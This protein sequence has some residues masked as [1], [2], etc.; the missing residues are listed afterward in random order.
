MRPKAVPMTV[1]TG[2]PLENPQNRRLAPPAPD[3]Q[4]VRIAMNIDRSGQGRVP[5]ATIAELEGRLTHFN[6]RY[7]TQSRR[8]RVRDATAVSSPPHC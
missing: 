1:R 2:Q 7:P 3:L 8:V 4:L 5:S 6:D